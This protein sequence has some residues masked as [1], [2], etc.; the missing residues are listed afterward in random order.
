MFQK[1]K[2][3][4]VEYRE[5]IF[6]FLI[7]RVALMLVAYFAAQ[8]IPAKQGILQI[9][10]LQSF[11]DPWTRWDGEW[12][13][14][15][16]DG[17][18]IYNAAG[19]GNVHFFPLYPILTWIVKLFIGN[20]YLSGGL[21]SNACLFFSL[22]LMYKFVKEKFESKTAMRAVFYLAV[23]PTSFF[24]SAVYS[25]SLF[26]LL[27]LLVFYFIEKKQW[28]PSS[29]FASLASA[30]RP[31]GMI[32]LPVILLAYL[33]DKGYSLRKI[34]FDALGI[35]L[36]APSGLLSFMLYQ[37][38]RFG[39]PFIFIEEASRVWGRQLMWPWEVILNTNYSALFGWDFYRLFLVLLFFYLSS[40]VLKKLGIV[41]CL[42]FL[43]GIIYPLSTGTL[44]CM[45]RYL[46]VLFPGF[47]A[48]AFL[49]EEAIWDAAIIV[50]FIIFLA[51]NVVLFSNGYFVA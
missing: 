45:D 48:L 43:L 7:T 47:I 38:L 14:S 29:I 51:F 17:G 15:I 18:Y 25:E 22:A 31:V 41:Y 1:L 11:L 39:N 49:G 3:F 6:V 33:E 20:T 9:P 10:S 16:V 24:F 44:A 23:F 2:N 5:P 32:F 13:K 19:E 50:F 37:Y 8:I 30:T 4:A 12:Y 46:A 35:I 40:I 34:K 28:L 27:S 26:L 36:I 42:Y 21:L